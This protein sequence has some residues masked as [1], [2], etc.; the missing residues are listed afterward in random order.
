MVVEWY[1]REG[2][3]RKQDKTLPWTERI[4]PILGIVS[5]PE[6]LSRR[7]LR[8]FDPSQLIHA[9]IDW[10]PRDFAA[11]RWLFLIGSVACGIFIVGG[12]LR[13]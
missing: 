4:I 10:S 9:G 7:W 6:I 1:V 5:I 2:I 11:F 12:F 13:L 3:S 8:T